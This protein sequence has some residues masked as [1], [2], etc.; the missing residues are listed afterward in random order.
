MIAHEWA[1]ENFSAP[2]DEAIDGCLAI[3]LAVA[4]QLERGGVS[5]ST[6]SKGARE[7]TTAG[8]G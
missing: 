8:A 3:Y 1:L 6:R 4:A 7:R 2:L 5:K